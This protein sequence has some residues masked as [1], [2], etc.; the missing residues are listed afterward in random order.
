MLSVFIIGICKASL[1][2]S[3]ARRL[4]EDEREN[5]MKASRRN[6]K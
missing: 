5:T 2:E 4:V 6:G 1:I 3:E